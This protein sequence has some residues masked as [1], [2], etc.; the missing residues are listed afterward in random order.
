M[1]YAVKDFTAYCFAYCLLPTA[2][3]CPL[4]TAYHT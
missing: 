2:A 3:Y 1:H 4:L